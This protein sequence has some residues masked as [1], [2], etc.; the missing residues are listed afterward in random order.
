M[1]IGKWEASAIPPKGVRHQIK[2][3]SA[4]QKRGGGGKGGDL[5]GNLTTKS[6]K[7]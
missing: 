7:L 2:T 4:M 5:Q 3:F 6:P 1:I